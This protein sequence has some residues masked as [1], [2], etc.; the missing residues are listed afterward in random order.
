M[1]WLRSDEYVQPRLSVRGN[2]AAWEAQGAKDTYQL[3]RDKVRKMAQLPAKP[4]PATSPAGR[5]RRAVQ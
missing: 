3:A 4:L 2:R 1:Q 5:R